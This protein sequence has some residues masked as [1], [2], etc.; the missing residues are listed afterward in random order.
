MFGVG[1]D[2]QTIY[3]YNGADPA[4]LIDFAELFPGAGDHPLEVNYRCPAGSVDGRRPPAAPQPPSGAPR[5]SAPRRPIPAAGRST[6]RSIR[7]RPAATRC[8]GRSPTVPRR[9]TSPC[10]PGSTRRWRRSR[11]R[12]RRPASRSPAASVSSSPTARR[13]AACWPGCGSPPPARAAPT[14]S[15]PTT[16]ARRCVARRDRSTHGSTTGSTEQRSVVDLHRLGGAAEQGARHRAGHRVRRRHPD[17]AEAG[18]RRRIDLRRGVRADRRDRP[19]RLGRHARRPPAGHEPCRAG[20]R[21]HWRSGSWPRCTTTSPRS[22][23]G[24]DRSSPSTRSTDGVL[25]S[26]VHRVKGQEWPHVVVHL[27]DAEQYPHRLADDVEEERRLFHVAITRASTHATIVTG[28]RPSPFVDELT[29]EPSERRDRVVASPGT[30]AATGEAARPRRRR[31][32]WPRRSTPTGATVRGAQG[33]AQRTARRQAGLRGVRQQDARG[34]RPDG[35]GHAS[36]SCRA[37]PASAR[38][39]SNSTARPCS[40]SS[41]NLSG[42][43]RPERRSGARRV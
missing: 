10:W 16:S 20:R 36:P 39:S 3:G 1:D 37:S 32:I 5:R 25:L 9:P 4:W 43:S 11:S 13:C 6:V 28:P 15:R 17:A 23:R 29:T 21:P 38:P 42:S 35:A 18:R 33:P 26:T 30:R 31:T 34:H 2:D 40:P 12:W 41:P 7:S 24:C 8:S 14:G 27:A 22:S 19:R